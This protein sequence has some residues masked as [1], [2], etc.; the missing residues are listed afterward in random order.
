MKPPARTPA[1]RPPSQGSQLNDGG[2]SPTVT[3]EKLLLETAERLGRVREG[4]VAVHLH[5][6]RLQH[7]NRDA[8][9]LR[10]AVRVLDPLA[11]GYRSQIFLLGNSDIVILCRDAP[12]DD[13]EAVVYK[14]RALFGK[15]PLAQMGGAADGDDS[16][17]TWYNLEPDYPKFFDAVQL[18]VLEEEGRRR[19]KSTQPPPPEPLTAQRLEAVLAV[20]EQTD[21]APMIQRQAAVLVGA[22]NTADVAFQEFFFSMADVK[23]TIAPKIDVMAHEWLFQSL[24][25]ELDRHMLRALMRSAVRHRAQTVSVNLNLSTLKQSVFQSFVDSL[26]P[27]QTL[28]V[29]VAV[30]DAFAD[31]PL[32]LSQRDMLHERGFKILLDRVTPLVLEMIDLSQFEADYFKLS[33]THDLGAAHHKR[34]LFPPHETVAAIGPERI[35]L[36]RCDSEAAVKWGMDLGISI[37]QG[38]FVDAMLA[39]V[40]MAKCKNSSQC[41]FAQCVARRA[42]VSGRDRAEC[43]N[44]V[45][46]DA[47]P[48]IRSPKRES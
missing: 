21:V 12:P 39:A 22:K 5:L 11:I 19:A 3:P 8:T 29:E 27:N 2:P 33:W 15:D 36:S 9:R 14:V 17:A 16:M 34:V 45:M 13:L 6:S 42:A 30:V 44:H 1:R 46:V 41:T 32:F 20:L 48:T 28:I 38:R 7:E 23:R 47:L 35:V 24:V 40:T 43:T 37:F 10:I 18:L 31:L 26:L 25:G 4:W